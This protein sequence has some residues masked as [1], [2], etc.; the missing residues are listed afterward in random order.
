MR[1][2]QR[3]YLVLP[4][5]SGCGSESRS[6]GR[7]ACLIVCITSKYGSIAIMT[8]VQGE[9][10]AHG[11]HDTPERRYID[12]LPLQLSSA[13]FTSNVKPDHCGP[14]DDGDLSHEDDFRTVIGFR[15]GR[16]QTR[17]TSPTTPAAERAAALDNIPGWGF[18]NG[19]AGD[20][21]HEDLLQP[22]EL[23]QSH[24]SLEP[25]SDPS[26]LRLPSPWTAGP[27]TF[28]G[29]DNEQNFGRSGV[30]SRSRAATGP[31]GFLGDL[32]LKRLWS[33]ITFPTIGDQG[34]LKD[35]SFPRIASV[36]ASDTETKSG[37][38]NGTRSARSTSL[39]TPGLYWRNFNTNGHFGNSADSSPQPSP[40]TGQSSAQIG[41]SD[42]APWPYR[43][44]TGTGEKKSSSVDSVSNSPTRCK[45][46]D[47]HPT[48][49]R[50]KSDQS[51]GLMSA[52]SAVS[53][54]GDDSRWENVSGQVNSRMKAIKDSL[55]DSN[56]KFPSMPTINFSALRPDYFSQKRAVSESNNR[57]EH[58]MNTVYNQ[59]T[60]HERKQIPT[61]FMRTSSSPPK[62][63][64]SDQNHLDSAL[65]RLSGDVVLM[66]GYRG[67]ILR[68]AEPPYRQLWVP[69][70]VGLNIRKVN[71]EVGLELEDEEKMRDTIFASGMLTHI[72]LV[73]ISRRLLKRLRHCRNAK[74]ERLRVHD[75]GYD[76][77]LSPHL[78][79][80][81]LIE[82]L[83]TL[84]CNALDVP[85]QDRGATIIAHSLGG[86]I[87][88]HAVNQ[89]PEL[90]AGVVYAGVPQY[91][92][93]I[94]GPFRNGDEVLL[95]SR[96]L[97]AQV[98]FTLR[99]SF[100]LL[101]DSGHCFL[102]KD[103]KEEYNV[104]FFNVETWKE[105]AFSPCIAPCLPALSQPER[106]SLLSSVSNSLPSLTSL[107]AKRASLS[108]S[109][110]KNSTTNNVNST[111]DA[112]VNTV[113]R[114]TPD[115]VNPVDHTFDMHMDTNARA[116][117]PGI[118]STP[119]SNP[120]TTTTIP[121]PTAL[122]YLSRTLASTMVFKRALAHIP[123]LQ[124]ANAYPP[125]AVLYSTN[126]PTVCGARVFGRDGIKRAD[127]YD[128]LAF[129]SGDGVVLA[130]AAM[131]P[132]GYRVVE[133]G[134][135]R[136]ERGHV[137]LLGDL[138]AVGRCL[139]GVMRA[140]GEGVGL[141]LRLEVGSGEEG[142]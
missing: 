93:N 137:G 131:V 128:N 109:S 6:A 89:R 46:S 90:F 69:V 14:D 62:P 12:G 1:L 99:T 115:I 118:F 67:S 13:S 81:K 102:D 101:P 17:L 37:P 50:T 40:Q 95:S 70:K 127:A 112:I 28:V 124:S 84:P 114:K 57:I 80:R 107:S 11:K 60:T 82:F 33:N 86:L 130:R 88:R 110:T 122:T 4:E 133:G 63:L 9:P 74:E 65:D 116:P 35:L 111:A 104:D 34:F 71:L 16:E 105:Y 52:L 73:D 87:T 140:R 64:K 42:T 85:A 138:E 45:N 92:V 55:Q 79:S 134:R 132:R 135:V 48:L 27:R 53:S 129:A 25:F 24:Q 43:R 30:K 141:G 75:Y 22:E 113:D 117:T 32:S 19:G 66:G 3:I 100:V 54:L 20:D 78:L 108:L 119:S 39:L 61:S 142:G 38:L 77:R 83:E 7:I 126:T 76:W 26:L 97:T 98:N 49:Q 8:E 56:L 58:S 59:S 94:L 72:G 29:I 136:T 5:I 139:E 103:T 10:Q 18:F 121:L 47:N 91:C 36:L 120:S 21:Y 2:C 31:S 23:Q 125:I 15:I 106:R 44:C 41:Q 96:V 123:T 68:S 51:L